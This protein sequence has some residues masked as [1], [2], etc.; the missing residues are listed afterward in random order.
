MTVMIRHGEPDDYDNVIGTVDT[1]WGG[2]RMAGAGDHYI[3]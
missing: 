2:R 3:R 1:W